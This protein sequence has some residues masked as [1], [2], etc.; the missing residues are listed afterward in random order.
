MSVAVIMP[1]R[2]AGETIEEALASLVAQEWTE[3]RA[4]VIDDGSADATRE[5]ATRFA[6]QDPRISV[7][8]GVRRGVAAARNAG[9]AHASEEWVL[10]LDADDTLVPA[11][12]RRM[13]ETLA[14]NPHAD[15]VHC[16][17]TFTDS[18][19][20]ELSTWRCPSSAE[21][22]FPWAACACP[23][24]I[25]ACV[26]RRALL[27]RTGGFDEALVTSEDFDLWQRIARAGARFVALDEYLVTYRV[28]EHQSW[29]DATRF[30]QDAFLVIERGHAPDPRQTARDL[31]TGYARGL[32][33]QG[34]YAAQ[35]Q[36][37]VWAAGMAIARGEEATPLLELLPENGP[38][39]FD[40][41]HLAES[42]MRAVPLVTSRP[43]SCW[44]ELWPILEP[45][46]TRFLEALEAQTG[47]ID[48]AK[49]VTT[50][51]EYR[52]ALEVPAVLSADKQ[53]ITLTST[54]ILRI[55]A[56]QG[57]SE[58]PLPGIERAVCHVY[59]SGEHLG[60]VVLPVFGGKLAKAVVS[61]A[62]AGRFA[63][64]L[65]GALFSSHIYPL[66]GD[67]SAQAHW[68]QRR[69]IL[70]GDEQPSADD[71]HSRIGWTIFLQ[72]LFGL[73]DWRSDSFY[74]SNV[75]HPGAIK[76]ASKTR[77]IVELSL[78]LPSLSGVDGTVEID[79][80]LG[81]AKVVALTLEAENGII[82]AARIRAGAL[83]SG[84]LELARVAAREAITS[85]SGEPEA[86]L[87]ER[88]QRRAEALEE[89]RSAGVL[90][91]GAEASLAIRFAAAAMRDLPEPG[92]TIL[93]PPPGLAP[94]ELARRAELPS[95]IA[96]A[97]LEK[98]HAFQP[99]LR[100]GDDP[101]ARSFVFPELA[102]APPWEKADREPAQGLSGVPALFGRHHFERLFSQG[103][104][105]WR[106][107]SPYEQR[108]YEQTLAQLPDSARSAVLE[109]GCAEGHFTVQLAPLVGR[110]K[111]ADISEL[112]LKRAA[113]RC[114]DFANVIYERLDLLNDA[115]EGSYDAIFC[116]EILYYMGGLDELR[117]VGAKIASALAPGGVLI[118]AHANLVVD[119]PVA[120]G[121]DW[122]MQYG[123]KQIGKTFASI[124]DLV[125][126]HE[127]V[128]PLYRIQRFRRR[129]WR[130]RLKLRQTCSKQ[131][132]R[133]SEADYVEP[134]P[135]VAAHILWHG[136]KVAAEAFKV[137]TE[138]LPILMYHA[139]AESGPEA[140]AR[141]R[142]TPAMFEAQMRYLRDTG[143]TPASLEEWRSARARNVPLPGRRV[144]ITF[145]DIYADFERDALQILKRYELPATLFVP[146]DK[147][148]GHADWDEWSGTALPLIDLE[149][150][151]RARDAGMRI[152]S[153]GA[154][155]R[156][157]AGISPAAVADELWRS[158]AT[159]EQALDVAV[160]ALAYPS[161]SFDEVA[162]RLAA[163]CFYR[164]GVTANDNLS[165]A[166]DR[167]LTLS[168]IEV[169]GGEDLPAFIRRM[170]E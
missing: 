10:F 14:A 4:I 170:P 121:F 54:A 154:S 122:R 160:D 67:A 107:A 41:N 74:N 94:S 93:A 97:M 148:G 21:D 147:I 72:E 24:A 88:L 47:V 111:A 128:T 158:R 36:M 109:I 131:P 57:W 136:G 22:L 58:L 59:Q 82:S 90:A 123:A 27:D 8:E 9:L 146:A 2:N 73:P 69:A 40:I 164:H 75:Q 70:L 104:D 142:I 49:G 153:H 168:R 35:L 34:R 20:Q 16:G 33:A 98:L 84:G 76:R 140:L 62:I 3:W 43:P 117:E 86:L 89:P 83:T 137:T 37:V 46:L 32:P 139:V 31:P 106:Y 29:F 151:R 81:G 114:S 92:A 96:A 30:L 1:A 162:E 169:R 80:T 44:F 130:D 19:G 124:P 15:A 53:A 155:H 79:V 150:L 17:W 163:A 39:L 118:T 42:L 95:D 115:I 126:D 51:L 127:M 100:V 13:M 149:G 28:R 165:T 12:L 25:H 64:P 65:L 141:W 108:K 143:F 113:E 48:L 119:D 134:E 156:Q 66:L 145:D 120:T 87:R 5:I 77:E 56:E 110:L 135:E 23:F 45:R 50:A 129:H 52:I 101:I 63:W 125:F 85:Y 26:F 144:L 161:G 6:E 102:C 61:D 105:P 68:R 132:L 103:V 116:C 157:L 99:A 138:R 38:P 18:C 60:L 11:M 159:L 91:G 7:V 71:L 55:D 133:R 166:G 152:G 167:D 112:A 78:P